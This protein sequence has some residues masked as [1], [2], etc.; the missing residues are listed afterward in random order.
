[1]RDS[2]DDFREF[3]AVHGPSLMRAAYVLTGNKHRAEDLLQSVLA[4]LAARWGAGPPD[5]PEAYARKAL[6]R[7]LVSW[8]RVRR[9]HEVPRDD[10]PD[11][12]VADFSDTSDLKVTLAKA[13][14][15]L[16]AKQR[17]LLYLRYYEDRSEAE[18]AEIVGVAVGT[19]KSQTHKALRRLREV[20]PE[21]TP[22]D[23]P[24]KGELTWST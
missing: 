5:H 3:A 20:V 13:L 9:H 19:V 16:P 8:W 4:K 24:S 12:T 23:P 18:T 6:Y 2:Y 14:L 17:A 11:R 22:T 1:M 15:Q 10:L 21:L 7:E